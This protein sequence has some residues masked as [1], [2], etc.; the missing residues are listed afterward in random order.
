ML[1]GDFETPRGDWVFRGE[2]AFFFRDPVQRDGPPGIERHTSFQGG[3]GADRR[4]GDATLFLN[5]LYQRAP[6]TATPDE[7]SVVF[8]LSGTFSRGTRTAKAFGIYNARS[9]SA[10]LRTVFSQEVVENL[11]LEGEAGVFLGEGGLALGL[12]S[13]SDFVLARLRVYF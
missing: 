11:R 10:F 1:G 4:M 5:A 7:V 3:V 8:G 6:G 13:D 9:E 2:G 12:L